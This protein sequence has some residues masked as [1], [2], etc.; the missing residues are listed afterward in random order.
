MMHC[1][2]M[3]WRHRLKASEAICAG[4]ARAVIRILTEDRTEYHQSRL[5]VHALTPL[6]LAVYVLAIII[7]KHP[8]AK[9]VHNDLLVSIMGFYHII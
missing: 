2:D 8:Q 1:A 9:L 4:S 5:L 3:P 6:L 7:L